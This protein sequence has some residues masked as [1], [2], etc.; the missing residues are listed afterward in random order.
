MKCLSDVL[1]DTKPSGTAF[2]HGHLAFTS[3]QQRQRQGYINAKEPR[4]V[5]VGES[6]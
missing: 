2:A 3:P 1:L 4:V 6:H 5:R